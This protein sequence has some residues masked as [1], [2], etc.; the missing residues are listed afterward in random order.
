MYNLHVVRLSTY[1]PPV[2]V[3]FFKIGCICEYG[4][5]MS[6]WGDEDSALLG[7]Y[8]MSVGN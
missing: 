5:G 2:Y 3:I 1:L 8:N 4:G 7:F 6:L